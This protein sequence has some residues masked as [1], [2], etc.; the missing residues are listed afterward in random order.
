[1]NK[2]GASKECYAKKKKKKTKATQ[3][4]RQTDSHR[5]INVVCGWLRVCVC[6]CGLIG[7]ART[8]KITTNT[9]H[10]A[11]QNNVH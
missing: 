4:H 2:E 10:I 3:T 11:I 5:P 6:V 7:N 9:K 1:M 8:K